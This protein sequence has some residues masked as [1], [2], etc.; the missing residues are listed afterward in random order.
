MGAESGVVFRPKNLQFFLYR[1]EMPLTLG[2]RWAV[3]DGYGA[4]RA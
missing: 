1:P 2:F 3:V 4:S